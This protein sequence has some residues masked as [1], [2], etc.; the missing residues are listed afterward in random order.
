MQVFDIIPYMRTPTKEQIKYF[1]EKRAEILNSS[2]FMNAKKILAEHQEKV[3]EALKSVQP[4][5]NNMM[6]LYRKKEEIILPARRVEYEILDEL[7]KLNKKESNK[8]KPK[9]DEIVI[10][11]NTEENTLS[12]FIDGKLFSYDLSGKRKKL[13]NIFKTQKRYVETADLKKELGCPTTSSVSKLVQAFN[14]SVKVSL[15]LKGIRLINGKSGFGY[16][17]NPRVHIEKE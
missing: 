2:G 12:R 5:I 17:I 3:A 1:N 16:R 15:N 11:Y 7:K 14:D 9:L 4:T 6:E 8:V 13:F 10:T